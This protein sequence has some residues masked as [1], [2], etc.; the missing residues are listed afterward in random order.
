[1]KSGLGQ[2]VICLAFNVLSLWCCWDTNVVDHLSVAEKE[3]WEEI[4]FRLSFA[5]V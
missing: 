1:M 2:M 3:G 5:I 4:E